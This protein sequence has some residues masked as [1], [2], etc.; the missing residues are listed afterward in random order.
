MRPVHSSNPPAPATIRSTPHM[1]WSSCSACD[2]A[3]IRYIK[4]HDTRRTC[5]SLLVALDVHP[6]VAMQVLKHSQITVTMQV[7]SEVPS[8][9]TKDALRRLGESLD[10]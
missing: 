10:G 4:I 8:D 2:A 7:Y 5:A 6:R 9:A 3:G 1:S